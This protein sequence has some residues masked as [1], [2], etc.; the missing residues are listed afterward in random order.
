M[1]PTLRIVRRTAAL[2]VL[3]GVACAASTAL[4]DYVSEADPSFAFDLVS[5]QSGTG[6]AAYVLELT[7]QSWRS[8]SEVDRPLWKHWLTIVFPETVAGTTAYLGITGGNNGGNPPG[9]V[10]S[11]VRDLAVQTKTVTAELR[12]VPNQPL[13]FAGDGQSRVEDAI[14]AFTFD[15]FLTTA[16]GTWPALLPMVKAAVRAMDAVQAFVQET[17]EGSVTVE[18]FVVSGASKRGW[19]TWL[20]AA[21][22]PRVKAIVPL[23]IDVLNM[24]EQMEHHRRVY[25]GI[26]YRTV[27]GYA[28]A[29]RDYVNLNVIQRMDTPEGQAL[30]AIVDPYEYRARL[31]LPKYLINATGDQ[32]F[33]PDS[34]QF[35]VK[36]L[37]G[38]TYLRYVPNTDHGLS[39]GS[40]VLAG[41]R[42]FYEAVMKDARLPEFSWTADGATITV[43]T[44]DTPLE[45]KLWQATQPDS[46]D[47]RLHTTGAIWKSSVLAPQ[48]DGGY[49]ARVAPPATGYRAFFVE[50]TFAVPGPDPSI[51]TTAVTVIQ[52]GPYGQMPGDCNQ[53]NRLDISDPI[54]LLLYLF[55]AT[56]DALPCGDGTET[57]PANILLIDCNGDGTI[58][59]GDP[60]TVL[61]ILFN[62]GSPHPLGRDCTP[63][64]GCP[65]VCISLTAS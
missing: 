27:G 42:V 48:K 58:D 7:S 6:Y 5:S 41:V 12:M 25:E 9:S 47:F 31:T 32:F 64:E 28:V 56:P 16:D 65:D 61:T 4:D 8:N 17:T 14:I 35:Y 1:A 45:V 46:R 50:L 62:G 18:T 19:T 2:L 30:L 49:V 37:Q 59:L 3:C 26:T 43:E 51:F 21:V 22:D 10:N 63:I 38:P 15:K 34:G 13:V 52:A 57:D 23:V 33:V 40:D 20:T 36:D 24:D 53:D 54:C 55:S 60:I 44:V 11:D 39:G 29:I